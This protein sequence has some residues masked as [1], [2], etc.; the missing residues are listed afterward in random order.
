MDYEFQ[1]DYGY[2]EQISRKKICPEYFYRAPESFRGEISPKSDV[3]SMGALIYQV[4]TGIRPFDGGDRRKLK[5]C[6]I[7]GVAEY[8][9]PEWEHINE[10]CKLLVQKM[11]TY[12]AG[13]DGAF[14]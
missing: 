6:I 1:D 8:E 9:I 7:R 10:E 5:N 2:M 4:M 12:S 13:I 3:W 11:L 14:T